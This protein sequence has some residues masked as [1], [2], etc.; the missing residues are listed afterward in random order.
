HKQVLGH[1]TARSSPAEVDLDHLLQDYFHVEDVR[2]LRPAALPRPI[3]AWTCAEKEQGSLET[4]IEAMMESVQQFVAFAK[5]LFGRDYIEGIDVLPKDTTGVLSTS[6]LPTTM[7][8]SYSGE[9]SRTTAE[10]SIKPAEVDW[11]NAEERRKALLL[12]EIKSTEGPSLHKNKENNVKTSPLPLRKRWRERLLLAVPVV[13]TNELSS[14]TGRVVKSLMSCLYRELKKHPEVDILL[15]CADE[16]TFSIAQALRRPALGDEMLLG[17]GPQPRQNSFEGEQM[18]NRTAP[19]TADVV[20]SSGA[21][22]GQFVGSHGILC[23]KS[24][25]AASFRSIL[26]PD[27]IRAASDLAEMAS[28]RAAHGSNKTERLALFLGA[29][30]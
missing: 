1:A 12:R 16:A 27:L 9:D 14:E 26:R 30:A 23:T 4:R 7:T 6:M 25:C 20:I 28:G 21:P 15:C 10:K 29:G 18:E 8:S 22:D 17:L 3:F 2:V 19:G 13:G 5:E 11:W 24:A